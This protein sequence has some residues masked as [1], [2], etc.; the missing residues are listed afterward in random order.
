MNLASYIHDIPD[1]PK[2]GII[3]KDISPL[4]M[5]AAATA[6]A[7]NQLALS[8]NELKPT[9]IVGI[10][11]RGFLLGILLAQKLGIGFIPIR[12]PGKLPGSILSQKYA[13]E[14]GEDAIEIQQGALSPNEKVIIHDDVLAT[15][16][17]ASAACKLVEKCGAEVL[18]C[19]FLI[20]L[21]F[22]KGREKLEQYEIA[23]LLNMKLI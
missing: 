8:I 6:E 13:L 22:L 9:K 23:S 20:E 21:D 16:G 4:L 10:E 15:G 3:F 19:N 5:D 7:V 14:Y 12:K 11:S 1:F 18:Q 2:P 17:T